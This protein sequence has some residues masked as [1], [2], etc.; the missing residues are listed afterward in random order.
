MVM[1]ECSLEQS[2]LWCVARD[3]ALCLTRAL[4]LVLHSGRSALVM[5]TLGWRCHAS[6][7]SNVISRCCG[8]AVLSYSYCAYQ[9]IARLHP[10]SRDYGSDHPHPVI[11][12]TKQRTP[13]AWPRRLSGEPLRVHDMLLCISRLHDVRI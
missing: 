9:R 7:R 8:P 1:D 6:V 10:P 5:S 2:I 4:H 3:C 11:G 13:E 12:R